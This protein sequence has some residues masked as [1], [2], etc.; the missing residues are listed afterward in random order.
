MEQEAEQEVNATEV[1]AREHG[2]VPEEEFEGDKTNWVNAETWESRSKRERTLEA[3]AKKTDEQ[4]KALSGVVDRMTAREKTIKETAEK[5][6]LEK[7]RATAKEA[8]AEGDEK[9]LDGAIDDIQ[10]QTEQ[11]AEQAATYNSPSDIAETNAWIQEHKQYLRA[12][13]EKTAQKVSTIILASHP[14]LPL[15]EHLALV[16]KEVVPLYPEHFDNKERNKAPAVEGEGQ[17][18]TPKKG[19]MEPEFKQAME[20]YGTKM[21][22]S[23]AYK[24]KSGKTG[25]EGFEADKKIAMD[26]YKRSYDMENV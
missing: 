24:G 7:F 12:D 10:K 22:R 16:H 21:A 13:V 9:K 19:T 8:L 11:V 2:W 17:R 3:N 4:L 26:D 5:D 15:K 14:G 18:L 20:K 6:A 1:T 25:Q 23:S